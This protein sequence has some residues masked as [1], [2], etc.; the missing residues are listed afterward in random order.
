M[1]KR[2]PLILAALIACLAFGAVAA[3][4]KDT[5]GSTI[6]V[7]YKPANPDD[8][9]ATSAFT[10]KVGPKECAADRKVKIKGVGKTFT[11]AKGKFSI[12]GDAKPG[13]YKVTAGSG[14][15]DDGDTC[16]KVSTKITIKKLD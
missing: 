7:K 15:T 16:K 13:K 9:Y 1:T 8:P 2:L 14:E 5:V 4:A 6:K 11:D 10:G 3:S 12:T